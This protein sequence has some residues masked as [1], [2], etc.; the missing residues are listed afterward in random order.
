MSNPPSVDND[1]GCLRA[2][3]AVPILLLTLIAALF[4]WAALTIR[5]SGPWDDEAY[6]AI[7]LACVVTIGATA[8]VTALWLIP[9][10]RRIIPWWC[11]SPALLLGIV[12][13]VQWMN[14]N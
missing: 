13:G 8:A 10:V 14:Q 11:I 9:S 3:L 6:A 7:I 12:A 1:T 2:V 5:P 4:C